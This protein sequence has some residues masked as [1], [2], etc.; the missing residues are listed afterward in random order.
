[1]GF[2][3]GD[4]KFVVIAFVTTVKV[5][6]LFF[7]VGHGVELDRLF[8]LLVVVDFLLDLSDGLCRRGR[9]KWQSGRL[10]GGGGES[11][12]G[13]DDRGRD[14]GKEMRKVFDEEVSPFDDSSALFCDHLHVL[15]LLLFRFLLLGEAPQLWGC[16]LVLVLSL[17][18]K[19]GRRDTGLSVLG[20]ERRRLDVGLGW[21]GG[22]ESLGHVFEGVALLVLV[23]M[24]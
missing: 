24:L 15:D 17:V 13:V 9:G 3:L 23:V 21:F 16:L 1:M 4:G 8:A 7:K 18:E 12:R 10:L 14:R 2:G 5:D 11:R 6:L 20:G 19:R 22:E